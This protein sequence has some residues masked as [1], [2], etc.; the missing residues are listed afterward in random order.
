MAQRLESISEPI[1]ISLVAGRYL[2]FDV[3]VVTY[4]R[5]THHICGTLIGSIPQNPQQ[6]LF[7]GLPMELMP[8]EAKLLIQKEVAYIVDD[9]A[10]H[11]QRFDTLKGEEKQKYLDSLRSIGRKARKATQDNAKKN[12]ENAL[13]RLATERAR[14]KGEPSEEPAAN[15]EDGSLDTSLK[16]TTCVVEDSEESIFGEKPSP[17]GRRG[18]VLASNKPYPVTPTTSYASSSL[19]QNPSP[20]PD[21]PVPSSYPLF[22]HLH[23]HGYYIMPGLRFG[24]DY[25]VY[26]GDPLRFHSHFLATS[27]EWD[28]E[29]PMLDLIGGGRLGTA[30]KKG[31]LI[32]GEDTEAETE[33]DWGRNVRTF[34]IEWGGM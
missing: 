25:N 17:L 19:P 29:I 31:F 14:G 6:N 27:F 13:A 24:C 23:S 32:G 2:I 15:L 3:N 9:L 33:E 12:T 11:K 4:L 22:A 8:E 21:P 28:Q 1:P 7:H 18:T 34:S 20:P 16:G 26:P 30:V 5:R 10:W